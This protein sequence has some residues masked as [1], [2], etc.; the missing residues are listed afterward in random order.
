MI[1]EKVQRSLETTDKK[2]SEIIV[3]EAF[4]IGNV[5]VQLFAMFQAA[6]VN[7]VIADEYLKDAKTPEEIRDGFTEIMGDLLMTLPVVKVAEYHSGLSLTK[8]LH[9]AV[10]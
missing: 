7:S 6:Y 2:N 10:V 4:A 9:Q 8:H 1:E 5:M 3:H